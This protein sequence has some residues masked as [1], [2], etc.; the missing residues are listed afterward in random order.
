MTSNVGAS[1]VSQRTRLGFGDEDSREITYEDTK[2]IY[3]DALRKKFK[4]EFLNRIDVVCVFHSLT[5]EDLTKIAKMMMININK[6]LQKQGIE[7]KLTERGLN[8]IVSQGTDSEYG[9]R[10]LKRFI[11]QQ[12]E[13]RIAEKV[14]LGELEKSGTII[15]D[16]DKN[17][18]I[19]QNSSGVNNQE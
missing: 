18:L 9:A 17:N 6:R 5:N 8:Y 7:L 2:R 15:I 3:I 12:I 16:Y 4:P 11:Q 13:D 19:F 1:E 14:L 10:P